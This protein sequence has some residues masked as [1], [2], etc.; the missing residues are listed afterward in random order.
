MYPKLPFCSTHLGKVCVFKT[1]MF[2]SGEICWSIRNCTS[3]Q[4]FGRNAFS[5]NITYISVTNWRISTRYLFFFNL[6]ICFCSE[7]FKDIVSMD[8]AITDDNILLMNTSVTKTGYQY[9]FH[10]LLDHFGF[11][12]CNYQ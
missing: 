3:S 6:R 7:A 10:Q 5:L 9:V 12:S 4:Y 11:V 2:I 1:H 8:T